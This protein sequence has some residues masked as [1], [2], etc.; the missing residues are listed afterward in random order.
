MS[1][2]V[3][4][5]AGP[6]I[7]IGGRV[8]R[9]GGDPF[10]IA[11]MSGN[12][13]QSLDTALQ[14]LQAAADAGADAVKL[15]TYTADTITLDVRTGPF[16]ITDEYSPWVGRKLY[17]LYE[18]AHTPWDWHK[19]LFDR[20]KE[21]GILAFST[22][23][24]FTAVDFLESLD[25]PAYKVAS[26]EMVDLP[27]IEKIA[28]TGKPMIM[29]TGMASLAE[30]C[31]A[32]DA[33]RGAGAKEIA[34]LKC[35]NAYPAQPQE[36]NLRTIQ[37]L[38]EAFQVP[39]GLSDHTLGSA[40]P[41]TAVALGASVIEKHLA[42]SRSLPG[43]DVAFSLEPHEFGEMVAAVRMAQEAIG[44]VDYGVSARELASRKHRRSLFAC[45][46]I[47]AGEEFTPENVR[48]V[49]PADGLPPKHLHSLMGRQA[50][51]DIKAGTPMNW[52]L[53]G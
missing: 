14:I 7:K 32:V 18:E 23:F 1:T 30:I 6:A 11:E 46:D 13:N 52:D 47:V 5:E 28:A 42:L 51:R 25:V 10:V 29:S 2:A 34:L 31:E 39:T 21:L 40:V 17:D 45:R 41:V 22:P 43:P 37:H 38:A 35:S 4:S 24:D 8:I 16:V 27:L 9:N 33:A 3:V 53:I 44:Q 50:K 49:R 26:F 19:P 36:M 20:A 48:S 12:H 15:Q